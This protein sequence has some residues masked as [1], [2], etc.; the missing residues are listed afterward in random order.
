MQYLCLIY[1]DE[2]EWLKL[3]PA[4]TEKVIGEYRAYTETV[5]RSGNFLGGNGLEPTH[6][7]TTVRVRKGRV[8]TTDGPFAETKEQLGGYYLL[9]ARDLNEAIQ[10]ASKIPGARLGSVEVRPVMEV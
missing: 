6:T 5:K 3:P 10:L 9:E 2:K 1:E 4:E 8:A 7:A